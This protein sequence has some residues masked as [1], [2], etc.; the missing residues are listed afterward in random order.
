MKCTCTMGQMN[1]R[2]CFFKKEWTIDWQAKVYL[3]RVSI[4][5]RG[6]KDEL[7][8]LTRVLLGESKVYEDG[9]TDRSLKREPK[10]ENPGQ[11]SRF[12]DS[13][14]GR[15]GAFRE[16]VIY[17]KRRALVECIITFTKVFD[18]SQAKIKKP[19][20]PSGIKLEKKVKIQAQAL[21]HSSPD[22]GGSNDDEADE[23]DVIDSS[24][25]DDDEEDDTDE[26]AE[27]QSQGSSY[28]ECEDTV[29]VSKA[30]AK[31]DKDLQRMVTEFMEKTK[32]R[33]PYVARLFVVLEDQD[34]DAAVTQ[35]RIDH[36]VVLTQEEEKEM[37]KISEELAVKL[38]LDQDLKVLD[39]MKKE[40]K[41]AVMVEL[42]SQFC[43]IVGLDSSLPENDR[44]ARTYLSATEWKT[45]LAVLAYFEESYGI[46]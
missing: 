40:D 7:I 20:D 3:E 11:G 15:C 43:E 32:E 42:V 12:Y 37:T 10:K 6:T 29:D 41:D 44:Q 45:D 1:R 28:E 18:D 34:V 13:V 9:K 23:T 14:Q 27:E 46:S 24:G 5:E 35:Y 36:T 33:S 19:V 38:K 4:S 21:S 17:E 30:L 16:F 39:N 2:R 22:P 8:L 25:S 26:K 31:D